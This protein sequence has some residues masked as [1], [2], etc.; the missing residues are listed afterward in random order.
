MRNQVMTAADA[1]TIPAVSPPSAPMAAAPMAPT[2]MHTGATPKPR[3]LKIAALET[4]LD[5]T[6][7]KLSG[8]VTPTNLDQK[9]L[10]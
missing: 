2:T 3:G 8:M 1:E 10:R 5:T 9:M 4:D 6:T 7:F